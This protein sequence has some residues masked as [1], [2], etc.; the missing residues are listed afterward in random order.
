MHQILSRFRLL[1]NCPV[2]QLGYSLSNPVHWM[3]VV[4]DEYRKLYGNQ[5]GELVHVTILMS[6]NNVPNRYNTSI[7]NTY[8]GI[9]IEIQTPRQHYFSF[10]LFLSNE[11]NAQNSDRFQLFIH[12]EY[13][14]GHSYFRARCRNITLFTLKFYSD[15]PPPSSS[16]C[17]NV[18]THVTSLAFDTFNFWIRDQFWLTYWSS[19]AILELL[20]LSRR[21]I[22]DWRLFRTRDFSKWGK[23]CLS[24]LF[25]LML[26]ERYSD[27]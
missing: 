1:L 4:L 25:I 6:R 3:I 8:R 11:P 22:R 27:I 10:Y 5:I 12:S 2:W 21:S 18:R 26:S 14:L 17:R 23:H 16:T 13:K 9:D 15:I 19:V 24:V 7:C 20:R